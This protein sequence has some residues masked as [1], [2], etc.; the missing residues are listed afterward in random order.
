MMAAVTFP[1]IVQVNIGGHLFTTTLSTLTQDPNSMLAGMF[2]GKVGVTKDGDGSYFIDRDGT[3]FRLILNFLRDGSVAVPRSGLEREQLLA[4]ARYYQV[5]GLL[6][7]LEGP[8]ASALQSPDGIASPE[9]AP[10]SIADIQRLGSALEA[11]VRDRYQDSIE[12]ITQGVLFNC[13]QVEPHI[14]KLLEC[15]GGQLP[16]KTVIID[17]GSSQ[18]LYQALNNSS[19]Q[20]LVRK[21]LSQ[22]GLSVEIVH[23]AGSEERTYTLNVNLSD[24]F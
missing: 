8:S 21:D 11:A 19:V 20:K 10:V 7:L 2:S 12:K 6:Q 24:L 1:E 22:L 17:K 23:S 3:H 16:V 9:S 13:M 5:E 18:E 14:K 15:N 4:A